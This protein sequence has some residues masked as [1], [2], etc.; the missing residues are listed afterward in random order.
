MIPFTLNMSI[1]T[2]EYDKI[3]FFSGT[4]GGRQPLLCATIIQSCYQLESNPLPVN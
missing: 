4:V 2:F 3:I 1:Y